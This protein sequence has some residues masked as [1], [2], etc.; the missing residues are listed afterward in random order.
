MFSL[1]CPP[2]KSQVHSDAAPQEVAEV[3]QAY[4]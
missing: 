3:P 2:I 1:F 4:M